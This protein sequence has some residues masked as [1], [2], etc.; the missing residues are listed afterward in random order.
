M[1]AYELKSTQRVGNDLT[2]NHS[3]KSDYI[4]FNHTIKKWPLSKKSQRIKVDITINIHS[5]SVNI[6]CPNYNK[7]KVRKILFTQSPFFIVSHCPKCQGEFTVQVRFNKFFTKVVS[8]AVIEEMVV[9]QE[10]DKEYVYFW[11]NYSNMTYSITVSELLKGQGRKHIDTRYFNQQPF[12]FDDI[13]L[14]RAIK[15]EF[16]LT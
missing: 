4:T 15:T 7:T 10:N 3:I 12:S 1:S 16:L 9:V 8:A 2:I 13:H 14:L 5:H 6:T 11:N